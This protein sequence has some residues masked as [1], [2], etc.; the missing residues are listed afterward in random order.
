MKEFEDTVLLRMTNMEV[1]WKKCGEEW[2][3]WKGQEGREL[4]D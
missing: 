2:G 4:Q 1:E 3:G